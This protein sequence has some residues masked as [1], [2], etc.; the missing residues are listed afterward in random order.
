MSAVEI[1][2]FVLGWPRFAALAGMV[3]FVI[4]AEVLARI[5]RRPQLSP[6]AGRVVLWGLIGARLGHV[7]EAPQVF[8]AEPWTIL[9][10]WQGGFSPWG[11]ALGVA[12]VTALA[13]RRGLPL[14]PAFG[15]LWLGLMLWLVLILDFTDRPPVPAPDLQLAM[16]DG[17]LFAFESRP[18]QPL[19]VNLWATWC[20]P[21]RRELPM[22]ADLA[23]TS[24]G[25]SF[26]LASQGETAA[27][28][29]AHLARAGISATHVA[30]DPEGALARHYGTIGLPVT[31]FLNTDGTLAHVHVGE[32][33]RAIMLRQITALTR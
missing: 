28:V 24:P 32:I 4:A 18:A 14:V 26:L 27:T 12:V 6:W 30:L 15:A 29:E 5:A 21:C 31:L 16:L 22:L 13:F 2:P 11:G 19:V 23:A 10:L 20:P 3:L 25:V 1:G 8:L 33:S 9:A 7:A 17:S